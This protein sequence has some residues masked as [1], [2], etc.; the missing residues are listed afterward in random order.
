VIRAGVAGD[1]GNHRPVGSVSHTDC[2]LRDGLTRPRF[3]EPMTRLARTHLRVLQCQP[4]HWNLL[5]SGAR[6]RSAHGKHQGEQQ[7]TITH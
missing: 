1:G 4:Q 2:G 5:R 3:C 6:S 7:S